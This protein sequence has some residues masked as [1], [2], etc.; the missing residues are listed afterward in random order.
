MCIRDRFDLAAQGLDVIGVDPDAPS[1]ERASTDADASGRTVFLC[2]DVFTHRFEPASFDVVAS[3]AMLHH[4]DA[5]R[6]LRRMR[7]LVRPG[8]CLLYTSDAADDLP[9]V[10]LGG[11]R[12][13]NTKQH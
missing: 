11:R 2:A 12:I 7:E 4:V 5:E 3:N 1:I 6:G 9:C 13:L 8:G 10:D